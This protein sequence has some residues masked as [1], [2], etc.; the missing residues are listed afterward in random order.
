MIDLLNNRWNKYSQNG[1][2]GVL[3][4]ILDI[5]KIENGFFV[6]FGANNGPNC[7]NTWLLAEK[8][9]NGI[10]IE[11]DSSLIGTLKDNSH[12]FGERVKIVE[13]YVEYEGENTLD[14]ILQKNSV[15]TD[16]DVLSIDI[17]GYDY[18]VWNS[19]KTFRPKIVIIEINS[20]IPEGHRQLHNPPDQMLTSFTSMVELGISKNY[21]PLCHTGNLIFI[22]SKINFT[23]VQFYQLTNWLKVFENPFSQ[24]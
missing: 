9:W 14:N 18:H 21:K 11:G 19:F 22:D 5:L 6:E 3:S 8:G 24:R 15:S 1:E 23:D 2:D 16:F 20:S 12:K 13:A 17:D 10:Y 7:S 4:S